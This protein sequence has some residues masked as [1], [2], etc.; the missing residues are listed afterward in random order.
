MF[1]CPH[2]KKPIN[3]L[4]LARMDAEPY[5]DEQK[6]D[7]RVYACP[8]DDCGVILGVAPEPGEFL[9][10][11]VGASQDAESSILR[12]IRTPPKKGKTR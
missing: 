9:S 3:N 6:H 4:L 11:A 10:D 8:H 12:A 7:V 1:I 5:G 2:C